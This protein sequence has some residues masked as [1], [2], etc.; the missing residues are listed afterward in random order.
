MT[1]ATAQEVPL[2]EQLRQA[3]ALSR[4]VINDGEYSTTYLPV[5][6]L[7]HKAADLIDAQTAEIDRLTASEKS[8]WNAAVTR[9]EEIER[10]RAVLVAAK[11]LNA[12][13]EE[14][15]FDYGL[16]RAAPNSYWEELDDAIEAIDAAKE[17]R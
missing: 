2:T 3:P 14:Y 4:I 7:M 6:V 13:S 11:G 1:D 5:G 16:G 10:L 9:D 8:A 15:D 12:E 17:Q